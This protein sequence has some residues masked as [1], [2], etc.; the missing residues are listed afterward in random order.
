M[1]PEARAMKQISRL[2][3]DTVVDVDGNLVGW[4]DEMV[5][6]CA[7]GQVAHVIVRRS[8]QARIWLEWSEVAVTSCG[9]VLKP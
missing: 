7:T 8:A 3:D 6:N 9:F 5:V 4:I 2:I 1:N